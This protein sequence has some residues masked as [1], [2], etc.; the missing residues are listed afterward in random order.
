MATKMA[1]TKQTKDN[2]T[3]RATTKLQPETGQIPPAATPDR[4]ERRQKRVAVAK[5]KPKNTKLGKMIALLQSARGTTLKEM[6]KATGWQSH[7]VRGAMSGAIRKKLGLH[8]VSE[9]QGAVR[10]YRIAKSA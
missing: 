6:T 5:R 2:A 10:T 7:S 9:K 3:A 4:T 1:K 8:I